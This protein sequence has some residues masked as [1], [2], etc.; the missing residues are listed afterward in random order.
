MR[1]NMGWLRR[2]LPLNRG[3]A[4]SSLELRLEFS[5]MAINRRNFL[6]GV[7]GACGASVL[8]SVAGIHP[9]ALFA[10]E[11]SSPITLPSPDQSG[12]N[13]IVVV[14]MENRSFDHL[15]GWLP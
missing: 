4:L 13:H 11:A 14:T 5:V 10:S 12:I 2:P 9:K 7:A 3:F 1:R 15:L 6:S 8:G